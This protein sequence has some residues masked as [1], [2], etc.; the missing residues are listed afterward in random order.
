LIEHPESISEQRIQGERNV[1]IRRAMIARY[2]TSR[3]PFSPEVEI[4]DADSFGTLYR[5]EIPGDEPLV[6][7]RVK[8]STPEPD[9]SIKEYFLRVPPTVRTSREAVAWTF[10]I[11][12]EEY[13][14]KLE[15]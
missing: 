10:G 4:L 13:D 9:G 2:G 3:Y 11:R 8:N 12:G 5:R 14:P 1:E 6:M 15:T 7:V